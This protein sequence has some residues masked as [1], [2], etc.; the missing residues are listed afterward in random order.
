MPAYMVI[1]RRWTRQ[2][3][4]IIVV[5][6]SVDEAVDQALNDPD[7]WLTHSDAESVRTELVSV[8]EVE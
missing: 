3:F 4:E 5:E 8:T 7:E 6:N 1:V 2:D